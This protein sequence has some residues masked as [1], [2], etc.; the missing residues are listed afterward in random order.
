MPAGRPG[1]AF[2]GDMLQ[3]K[4]AQVCPSWYQQSVCKFVETVDF[5]CG[6]VSWALTVCYTELCACKGLPVPWPLATARCHI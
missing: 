3:W 4:T 5:T 1:R 6:R 2:L